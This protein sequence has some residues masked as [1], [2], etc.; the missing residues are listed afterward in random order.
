MPSL[1]IRNQGWCFKW[2][3]VVT[4]FHAFPLAEITNA[5]ES[6]KSAVAAGASV[7]LGYVAGRVIKKDG[8]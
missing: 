8:S 5:L 3:E 6:F 2:G 4:R 7:S 1:L